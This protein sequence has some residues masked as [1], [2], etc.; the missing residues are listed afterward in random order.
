MPSLPYLSHYLCFEN[1]FK[2]EV[3]EIRFGIVV[4]CVWLLMCRPLS[5]ATPYIPYY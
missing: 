1:G 4:A 2:R 3:Q 5:V